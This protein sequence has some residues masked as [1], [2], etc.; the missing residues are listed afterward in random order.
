MF[1]GDYILLKGNITGRVLFRGTCTQCFD[2]EKY[3]DSYVSCN[4]DKDINS[5][6]ILHNL[7]DSA[8]CENE[9]CSSTCSS[10][11]CES[12]EEEENRPKK[13]KCAQSQLQKTI[14][15]EA[16][17]LSLITSAISK[18][19][20]NTFMFYPAQL[21]RVIQ[22]K[23]YEIPFLCIIRSRKLEKVV[24]FLTLLL[25]SEG[26]YFVL[27]SFIENDCKKLLIRK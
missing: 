22:I 7:T 14:D 11:D 8:N 9:T 12:V 6:D 10:E 3:V 15:M 1:Q 19:S 21:C 16:E 18:I 2:A 13:M 23:T 4:S 20:I 27:T 25:S 26:E 24:L 5:D 17:K